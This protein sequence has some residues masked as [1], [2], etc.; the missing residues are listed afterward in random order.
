M[1]SWL[2]KVSLSARGAA[3]ALLAL[4]L[5]VGVWA[6][7][8]LP[9]D[10][11][12]D[13]STVQ[14]AVLT[15]AAGLSP[16]EI[17]RTVSV[18]LE[19]ALNGVPGQSEIRSVSRAGLSAVT[20]I[21]HD[22][23]DVWFARQLILERLRGLEGS[24]PPGA[25]SPQLAPVSTGLG[26]IY[27]FVVRSAV[28]SPMQLRTLLDWEIVPRL[29]GVPGVIEVNTQGGY[30]KQFQVVVDPDRIKAFHIPL[31]EVVEAL[32]AANLN[33]GGGHLERHGE[34]YTLRGEGLLK[35]EAE[36]AQ[37]LLR[38]AADG[39]PVLV[40]NVAEVHVG[41][42]LRYGTV[43]YNGE[44]EAVTGTV[45]MLLGANSRD[46]VHAV[47]KRVEEIRADLPA[48]VHIDVVYDRADFVGRTLSTV[49]HNLIEGVLIVTVVLALFLGSL[50]G[51][52]A[53]VLGIPASMSAALIGMHVFHVTGDL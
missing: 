41:A 24:L 17:E 19:N 23:T 33:V 44:G 35:D 36:I 52:L 8:T 18:P 47:G 32:R 20:V 12:P 29:R 5:G 37:V 34:S 13:V 28:H 48:G 51:A 21:F 9:I 14:V 30:L 16:L 31:S 2:A 7:R 38:V 4:L 39:T 1:L 40:K 27:Q 22:D 49:V 53:V 46:V 25:E 15:K 43:T 45:L 11:L 3:L 26:E 6:A 10:A 50:R 42:A